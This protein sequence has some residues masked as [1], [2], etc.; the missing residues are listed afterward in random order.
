VDHVLEGSVRKAGSRIR[1]TAQW[2]DVNTDTHLWSDT[3]TR[4]LDDIFAVQDEISSAIVLAL[5][6]T[7]SGADQ[8][9]MVTHGTTNAEAYN[10]YLLGRHLWN[11]RGSQD[12][13]DAIEPLKEAIALDPGYDQAWAALAEAYVLLP[14]YLGGR[15]DEFIPLGREATEKALVLNPVSARA[16]TARGYIKSMYEYDIT[17]AL[18]D[19]ENAIELDPSYPTAHQWYGELLAVV[20]RLDEALEQVRIAKE[21]DPL[22]TVIHHVEGWLLHHDGRF[23]E[24]LVSYGNVHKIDPYKAH[25]YGNLAMLYS[26]SG[27]FDLARQSS[28]KFAEILGFDN[29]PMLAMIDALENPELNGRA[30]KLIQDSPIYIDGVSSNCELYML[31]GEHELTIRCLEQAFELG[32]PYAIHLNRYVAYDPIREDPRI[33]AL[34]RKMNLLP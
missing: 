9:Q 15:I 1:V 24:A 3:Y 32:D 25:T 19:Y 30:I 34:L 14:E 6:V 20:L 21:L 29:A 10:K 33:Q 22:S 17:G 31:M 26:K 8:Q 28:S 12:L 13:L 16:L 11:K 7:L 4:E 23:E 18:A 2:I 5:Q 27:Q